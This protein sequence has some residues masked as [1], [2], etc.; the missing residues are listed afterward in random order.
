MPA[1][2]DLSIGSQFNY[3]DWIDV[4]SNHVFFSL[5]VDF[6]LGI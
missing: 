3:C 5:A 4:L 6:Q 2:S 1:T